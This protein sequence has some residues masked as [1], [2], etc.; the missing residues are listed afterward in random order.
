MNSFIHEALIDIE[1]RI[2]GILD[3]IRSIQEQVFYTY[4]SDDTGSMVIPE[5]LESGRKESFEYLINNE[6]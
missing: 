6:K 5:E 1:H 4:D 3:D 2:Q